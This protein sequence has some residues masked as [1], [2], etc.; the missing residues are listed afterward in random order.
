MRKE[1]STEG[2]DEVVNKKGERQEG[3][4][5]R[6]KRGIRALHEI[7]KYQSGERAINE[8][9][10]VSENCE[11]SC[12]KYEGRPEV[13]DNG[14]NGT[15]TGRGSLFSWLTQTS[16]L[17]CHACKVNHDYAKRYTIGEMH[18]GDI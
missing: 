9:A 12:T 4:M 7:K 11:R 5:G 3:V 15:T 10:V 18:W 1:Q 2:K 13:A 6:L 16:Q 17:M 8:K 14:S